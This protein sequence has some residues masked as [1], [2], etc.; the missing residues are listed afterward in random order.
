MSKKY[1]LLFSVTTSSLLLGYSLLA[2]ATSKDDIV[3]PVAELNGCANEREC[4]AYCDEPANITAC[5]AFAE[6]HNLMSREEVEKATKFAHLGTGPGGCDSRESCEVYCSD[7]ANIEVCVKF[8]EENDLIPHKEVEEAKKI[9]RILR[10]G[11]QLP[12]NCRGRL[13]CENY[14]QNPDHAEECL[15][16]GE[17]AGLMSPEELERA[18]KFIPLMKRGETPGSCRTKEQ[19]ENYC[20]GNDEHID[21]CADF[22]LRVGAATK[23]EMEMFKKTRGRGP[24]G[25]KG[26][27]E[28]EAFCNNPDNQEACFKFAEEHGFMKKE[29]VEQMKEHMSRFKEELNKFPPEVLECIKS[30]AG[31]EIIEKIRNGTMTPGPAIG[32]HIQACFENF[33]PQMEQMME[34]G[35]PQGM[36]QG[37]PQG[38][39]Q[40]M[41]QGMEGQFIGPGGCK[42]SEECKRY[43]SDPAHTQECG[44]LTAPQ[45][46]YPQPLPPVYQNTDQYNCPTD[47]YWDPDSKTCKPTGSYPQPSQ[48]PAGSYWDIERQQCTYEAGTYQEPSPYPSPGTSEPH[49]YVPPK[50]KYTAAILRFL[51][52]LLK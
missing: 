35:M 28:C 39:Q 26:R 22:A 7:V 18:K 4:R 38:M 36:E 6:K 24:G 43:C 32:Q 10:E 30:R 48:C 51:I 45:G 40:G 47:S 9:A 31:T 14:C 12:G 37:M 33:R 13:Q 49:G 46:E 52:D 41:P 23:E 2:N 29:D 5:I 21:E 34:Q 27:E 50:N 16:F 3:F 42:T 1:L 17:E 11:R 8:A 25:C 20:M 44:N 15:A 19:C